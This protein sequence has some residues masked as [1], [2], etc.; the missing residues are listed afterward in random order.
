MFAGSYR[1][2]SV[3]APLSAFAAT[4]AVNSLS[5]TSS[6]VPSLK[7]TVVLPVMSWVETPDGSVLVPVS[8]GVSSV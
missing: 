3:V 5:S 6:L 8:V 4:K 2:R 7:Y 1:S